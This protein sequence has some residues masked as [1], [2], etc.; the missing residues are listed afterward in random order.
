MS[1]FLSYLNLCS[2]VMNSKT[3]LACFTLLIL[4]DEFDYV[5]LLERCTMH[6]FL[7]HDLNLNSPGMWLSPYKVGIY[8]L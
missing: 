4:D 1:H 8:K 5:S 2:K 6:F 7:H 3:F